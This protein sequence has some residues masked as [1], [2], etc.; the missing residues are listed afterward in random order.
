M[1]E[2]DGHGKK[3]IENT[4]RKWHHSKGKGNPYA[5]LR[6]YKKVGAGQGY[7]GLEG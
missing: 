4:G 7:K 5:A 2:G 1:K 6:L 3:D